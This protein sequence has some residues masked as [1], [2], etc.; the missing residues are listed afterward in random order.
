MIEKAINKHELEILNN[1]YETWLADTEDILNIVDAQSTS[2]M[3]PILLTCKT[4]N[5][6][7]VIVKSYK[8]EKP[9]FLAYKI[10]K[11]DIAKINRYRYITPNELFYFKQCKL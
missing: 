6:S 10:D 11:D 3:F 9:I 7:G 8:Y 2:T 5:L 1:H 4:C